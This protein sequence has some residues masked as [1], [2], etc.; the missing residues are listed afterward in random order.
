MALVRPP[1]VLNPPPANETP[2]DN[3][4][5]SVLLEKPEKEQLR[6]LPPPPHESYLISAKIALFLIFTIF[7]LTFCFVVHYGNVPIGLSGDLGLPFL[8]CEHAIL[9]LLHHR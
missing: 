3:A 1:P 4:E 9:R 8:H 2:T 5:Q 6:Q 7:Y